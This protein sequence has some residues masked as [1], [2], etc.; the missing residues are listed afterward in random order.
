MKVF[1]HEVPP[2]T[3]EA[4]ERFM[5]EAEEFSAADLRAELER[6]GIPQWLSKS[7]PASSNLAT[8]LIQRHRLAGNITQIRRFVWAWTGERPAR[9]ITGPRSPS[10][11]P[12]H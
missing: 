7:R 3:I 4:A 5:C 10:P 9:P 8:Y 2:A 6:L 12:G 11:S 1:D